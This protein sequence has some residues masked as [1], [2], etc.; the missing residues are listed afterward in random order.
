MRLHVAGAAGLTALVLAMASG[1]LAGAPG[2]T[3]TIRAV[4][5]SSYAGGIEGGSTFRLIAGQQSTLS[6]DDPLAKHNVVADGDGP[7]GE[8]LFTTALL[9]PNESAP[10]AG[11]PYLQPGS[12]AFSCTIHSDMKGAIEVAGPGAV[13][14][15]DVTVA[16]DSSK[17]KQLGKGKLRVTVSASSR[18]DDVSVDARVGGKPGGFADGVDL[19][20]GQSRTLRLTLGKQ[21]K[22]A[23]KAGLEKGRKVAVSVSSEVPWGA[24]DSAKSKL[25]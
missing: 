19:A 8:P 15:P 22:R 9:A 10:V 25:R 13:P 21:A 5:L 6:N 20:A 24:P 4:D 11:T 12:Y 18:S 16:V 23:V 7:D 3:D 2:V 14:R 17:L 1:A